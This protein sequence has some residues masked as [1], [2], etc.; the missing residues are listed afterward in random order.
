MSTDWPGGIYGS[1]TVN[2]SRAG[3]IIAS[4]WAS[5]MYFGSSGYLEATR[6]IID[7]TKYIEREFVSI[8]K[9]KKLK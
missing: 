7:T 9:L 1:P 2:G 4:C 8:R 3:G 5:I 6:K